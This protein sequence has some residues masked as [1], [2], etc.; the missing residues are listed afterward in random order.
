[1]VRVSLHFKNTAGYWGGVPKSDGGPSHKK[2]GPKTPAT[3]WCNKGSITNWSKPKTRWSSIGS[4]NQPLTPSVYSSGS[5]AGWPQQPSSGRFHA[6]TS[7]TV[8]CSRKWQ[9]K[10]EP[11]ATVTRVGKQL[12]SDSYWVTDLSPRRGTLCLR[13]YKWDAA[14]TLGL[15]E[16]SSLIENWS[17]GT[18]RRVD[19]CRRVWRGERLKEILK[20]KTFLLLE[21]YRQNK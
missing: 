14:V 7:D 18:G 2:G 6:L 11:V 1:M 19:F 9:S 16:E 13:G 15:Q 5:N 12:L 20:T 21:N 3:D 4:E 17:V 8:W 10:E